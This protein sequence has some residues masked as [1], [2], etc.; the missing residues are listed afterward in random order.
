MKYL[1][2]GDLS[3]I[4]ADCIIN[5]SRINENFE[6]MLWQLGAS[7][8]HG[9]TKSSRTASGE[10]YIGWRF[11]CVIITDCEQSYVTKHQKRF[12]SPNWIHLESTSSDVP[13]TAQ[14][15]PYEDAG[16]DVMHTTRILSVRKA[17]HNYKQ[18]VQMCEHHNVPYHSL[19]FRSWTHDVMPHARDCVAE[20]RPHTADQLLNLIT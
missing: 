20:G 11:N 12:H 13:H 3:H 5:Q 9:V 10:L 16:H 15:Q 2:L 19:R 18:I 14:W 4:Q 17:Q 7:I 8:P 6:G 1:L